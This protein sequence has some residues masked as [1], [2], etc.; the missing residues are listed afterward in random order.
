MVGEG[1]GGWEGEGGSKKGPNA[2]V[3]GAVFS[4]KPGVIIAQPKI[5]IGLWSGLGL[6]KQPRQNERQGTPLYT[7]TR[8]IDT[9]KEITFYFLKNV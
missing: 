5:M 3:L 7:R 2:W 9:G 8:K 1:A 6:S 4:K